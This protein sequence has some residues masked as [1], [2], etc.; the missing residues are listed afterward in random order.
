ML[1]N[2]LY[3]NGATSITSSNVI[4]V[5]EKKVKEMAVDVISSFDSTHKETG[6]N[7]DKDRVNPSTTTTSLT[8]DVNNK[9]YRIKGIIHII[10]EPVLYILQGVHDIFELRPSDIE[11]G[12]SDDMSEGFN[13]VI[14]IGKELNTDYLEEIFVNCIAE[15]SQD[16]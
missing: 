6:D 11:I 1:D 15:S 4:T 3:N 5:Q 2:L 14:V 10:H 13:R 16:V 9:I 7:R 12:S 8:T